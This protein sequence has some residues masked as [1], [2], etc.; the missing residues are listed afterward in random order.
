LKICANDPYFTNADLYNLVR[1]V[2]GA[3]DLIIA[4]GHINQQ[5]YAD[6]ILSGMTGSDLS[7]LQ[8]AKFNLNMNVGS[9]YD[10]PVNLPASLDEVYA[11]AAVILKAPTIELLGLLTPEQVLQL[12][13]KAKKTIFR[14][15]RT[16]EGE[17]SL[18]KFRIIYLNAIT[19]YWNHVCEFLE[20]EYPKHAKTKTR[21][22]IFFSEML[23]SIPSSIFKDVIYITILTAVNVFM[24]FVT[25]LY[26]ALKALGYHV[27]LEDTDAMKEMREK[28]PPQ[29]WRVKGA[30]STNKSRSEKE[31]Q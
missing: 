21:L 17:I 13:E 8:L 3:K 29:V 2:E 31:T 16:E 28:L 6:S 18:E 5:C 14:V 12:R 30:W 22:G 7:K 23:P 1:D 27:L 26:Y 24:P 19:K 11:Q 10:V 9:A 20:K 25:P 4:H 15:L